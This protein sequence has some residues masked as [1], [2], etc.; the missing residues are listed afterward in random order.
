[1]YIYIYIYV[2]R[3]RDSNP[4]QYSCLKN[5]MDRGVWRAAVQRISE[6]SDTIEQLSMCTHTQTHTHIE[7]ES[8][9][10]KGVFVAS[11]PMNS[12]L[13]FVLQKSHNLI[14]NEER[15]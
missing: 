11:L 13:I 1:M 6:E 10:L 5:P 9:P 3:E 12:C 2:E 4:L 15:I 14:M 7:F 8:H